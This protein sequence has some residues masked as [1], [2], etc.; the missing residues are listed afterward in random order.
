MPGTSLVENDNFATATARAAALLTTS[1]V[2]GPAINIQGCNQVILLSDFTVGSSAGCQIKAEVSW[3]NTNY[4]QI[5]KRE[6]SGTVAAMSPVVFGIAS[7][8]PLPIEI[9]VMARWLRVKS[10]AITSGT[11]T[12]LTITAVKGNI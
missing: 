3:D 4:Y 12:G 5:T 10:K 9:P 2:T 11:S 8:N 6:V 1:F 7:T